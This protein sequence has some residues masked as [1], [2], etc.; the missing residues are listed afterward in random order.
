MQA[1]GLR[2]SFQVAQ[3]V[4]EYSSSENKKGVLEDVTRAQEPVSKS[5]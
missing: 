3:I 4:L 1:R 2:P 5:Y